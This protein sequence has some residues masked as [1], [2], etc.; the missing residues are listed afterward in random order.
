MKQG[1]FL[2][3]V[4]SF[5]GASSQNLDYAH[6]VMQDLSAPEMHGR[7]YIK[8]GDLKAAKYIR[9]ELML[10]KV[11]AFNSDYF[12]EFELSIN[13]FPGKLKLKI[14]D[15]EL[16]PME[17][18]LVSA[19]SPTVKG[20]FELVHI[21]DSIQGEAM[22]VYLTNSDLS[23]KM[24]VTGESSLLYVNLDALNIKGVIY[25][26]PNKLY[27]KYADGRIENKYPIIQVRDSLISG[28]ET[29]VDLVIKSRFIENYKTQNVIGYIPGKVYP[30]SFYLFTGHYDHLGYM[31]K[32]IM[33]PGANDNASGIAMLLNLA[34]HYSLPENQPDYSIA[35]MAFG[36]EESG[37]IG[38]YHYT[39]NPLFPLSNIKFV[40]NVDMVG[41]GSEGIT[42][43]N[44]KVQQ[45][46]FD[47][48]VEINDEKKYLSSIKARGEA[49]NSDHYYFH[50][51]DV[52][53][54]FIYTRGKEHREYHTPFDTADKVPLTKFAALFHLLTDFVEQY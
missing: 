13:T 42:L 50:D 31:G 49:A 1:L 45:K 5:L 23:G 17:D 25:K 26:N 12:Q 35:F 51:H 6:Q 20:S 10:K 16:K 44:G 38:S 28:D 24:V 21:P 27:W 29:S 53:A 18:F 22:G 14:E 4:I 19:S 39:E 30:D 11:K 3:F 47:T 37:L 2:L 34:E 32:E 54:V 52:P 36:A 48:F 33:F 46:A 15:R 40:A 7:G 41:S 9:N 8:N 43:V